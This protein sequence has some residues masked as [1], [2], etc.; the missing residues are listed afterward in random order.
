MPYVG[1]EGHVKIGAA[2]AQPVH[3]RMLSRDHK[4]AA[5]PQQTEELSERSATVVGIVDS[6][7]TNDEIKRPTRIGQGLA[8]DGSIDT[9]PAGYLRPGQFHHDW[10]RVECRH[11]AAPVEE[12]SGVESGPAA[13]VEHVQAADR[14][15]RGQDGGPVVVSVIGAVGCV[16]LEVLAHPVVSRPQILSQAGTLATALL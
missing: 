10:A 2:L 15:K 4:R 12:F 1:L 3:D 11:L 7:R 8:K 5:R 14:S 16:P 13:C 6:Q 9:S